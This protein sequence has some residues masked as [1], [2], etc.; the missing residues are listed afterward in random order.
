[1]IPSPPN[2]A[3]AS[4]S[5][6]VPAAPAAGARIYVLGGPAQPSRNEPRGTRGEVS[7]DGQESILVVNCG[8]SSVKFALF[9]NDPILTRVWSGA[10]EGVGLSSG[11]FHIENTAGKTFLDEER[12]IPSHEVGLSL[13]LAVLEQNRSSQ[14]IVAIGHRV[15]HGGADCDCPLLI[16]AELEERL[17]R[18]IPLAPLHL[19]H[20][21]A[22]IIAVR[23]LR[24]ALAQIACFDTALHHTLSRPAQMTGLP[25]NFEA[26][27]IRRYG[28]HGLSFEYVV[29]EIRNRDDAAAA[30]ERLIVAHL[31]NGASMAAIKDGRSVDV[32]TGFSTLAGLPMGTRSGDVDPGI[33]FHLLIEER[34]AI[35]KLQHILYEKSGLLGLSGIS[36][37]MRELLARRN[38]SAAAEAIDYFCYQ[39]RKHLAA[40]TAVLGGLDRLV[41]TG[42]IGAN[43]PAIRAQIAAG[44]GYLGIAIDEA[45]NVRGERRISPD[46]SGVCV[47]AFPT[48][49]E[50]MIARHAQRR[51]VSRTVMG[52]SEP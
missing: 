25:R 22:G 36:R 39:A 5:R 24:P 49:E 15:V 29:E 20:N 21:L 48:D 17:H 32:T 44:L 34:M 14:K 51:L 1:M 7:A 26:K 19:P 4:D 30:Q 37:N 45:R 43:A 11:R 42:G 46:G 47:E 50:R 40:L 16:D 38:E 8:S 2:P 6:Q 10:V 18:L 23:R 52:A 41:F 33:I 35:G 28:F 9:L 12:P 31:G 27:G 13:L 3:S